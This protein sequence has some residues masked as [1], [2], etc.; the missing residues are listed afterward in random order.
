A[1]GFKQTIL[2]SILFREIA[3]IGGLFTAYYLNLAPGG[4][5]VIISVLL[6]IVTILYQKIHQKIL[7][8][9]RGEEN[10]TYSN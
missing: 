10:G 4:A 6:L 5:I 1:K 8:S 3:V 7:I 9:K 2:L